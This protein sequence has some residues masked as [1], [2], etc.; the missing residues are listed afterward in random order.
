MKKIIYLIITIS[1]FIAGCTETDYLAYT[2]I[3]RVQMNDTTT[4]SFT[5]VYENVSVT[6]DT[7][8]IRVNTI[9][10][11]S[12]VDREVKLLQV[13]EYIYTYVRDP[14]TGQI[15]DTVKTERPNKAV[16]GVHYVDLTDAGLKKF[17]VVKANAVTALLPVVLLRDASLKSTGY[18]MRLQIA[19][20]KDFGLGEL[21]ARAKTIIFSDMLE[22]F[23]S[24]RLDNYTASAY[25]SF[26][27]YSVVK[28]QFMIDV[29]GEV[30]DE[31]W[32]QTILAIQATAHY[33]NLF[34]TALNA[35][36]AN[37]ANQAAGKAPLRETSD[38]ASPLVT[39][40]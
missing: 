23:Y 4:Q 27:K 1:L 24:W 30:I 33:R 19:E 32:Y 13:P 37:L 7:V 20:T 29:S 40:P 26:G 14:Q 17:Y 5:F 21:K 15:T 10:N 36:N 31:T 16:S 25:S 38:P 22:R 34:K 12:D 6:K 39:F 3:N 9:G 8:W 35:F 11:V 18:R 28:H 2:D